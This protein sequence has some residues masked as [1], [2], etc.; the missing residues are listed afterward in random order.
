MSD[1][2]IYR[3]VASQVSAATRDYRALFLYAFP[4]LD[5]LVAA[6]IAF[7]VLRRN[8]VDTFIVVEPVPPKILD[9][10][11]LLLGYPA[12]IVDS[13]EDVKAPSALVGRGVRPQGLTRI[14]VVSGE[15][16]SIAVMTVTMLS[17]LTVVGD[18]AVHAIA[19]SYWRRLDRGRR[20]EF[21][22]IEAQLV[23]SLEAEGKV[24]GSLTLRLF[25]W[26]ELDVEDSLEITVDPFLPGL[27]GRREHI[28]KMF[29]EDPRLRNAR[30]R[31]LRLLSDET[32]TLLASKLYD[33]LKASSRVQRRPSELIGYAYYSRLSPINDLRESAA[34]LSCLGEVRPGALAGLALAPRQVMGWI[35][36]LY[37]KRFFNEIVEFIDTAMA[38]ALPDPKRI[39]KVR[40]VATSANT[41]CTG[42]VERQLQLLGLIASDVLLGVPGERGP[43]VML[44][45]LALLMG[46]QRLVEALEKKCLHYEPPS[47]MG[48]LDEEK[49]REL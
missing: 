13:I 8:N 26:F 38:G 34:L 25:R 49:C 42:V 27:T 16:A 37:Y 9:Q 18:P 22:G 1:T 39:G 31:P 29:S 36:Y 3:S 4:D 14:P 40:I 24:E 5:S 12:T 17:E 30:G 41:G 28:E 45:T 20:G 21:T 7:E 15:D 6:S 46:Y 32:I 35:H 43:K 33:H 47:L 44:E 11:S 48:E 19:A 23:E 10:P 2:G